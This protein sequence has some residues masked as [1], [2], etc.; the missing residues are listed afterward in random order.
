MQTGIHEEFQV[1]NLRKVIFDGKS[2]TRS[3]GCFLL[4]KLVKQFFIAISRLFRLSEFGVKHQRK[5]LCQSNLPLPV[6]YF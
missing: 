5:Y 3:G 2:Q 1:W 6:H 4:C